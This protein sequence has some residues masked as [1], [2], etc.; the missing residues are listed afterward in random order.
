MK[1]DKRILRASGGTLA[2][3]L[4]ASIAVTASDLG[5]VSDRKSVV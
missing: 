1:L 3:V 2:V 5:A 4:A